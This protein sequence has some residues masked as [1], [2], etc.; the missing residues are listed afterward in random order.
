MEKTK[1][2]PKHKQ[3]GLVEKPSIDE[4]IKE[5]KMRIEQI[6]EIYHQE[7]GKLKAYEEMK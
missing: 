6:K 4:L 7:I 1:T 5:S 2:M 3:N